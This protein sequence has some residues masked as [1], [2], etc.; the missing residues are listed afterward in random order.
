MTATGRRTRSAVEDQHATAVIRDYEPHPCRR[1][2]GAG[3]VHSRIA[4]C[5]AAAASVR[6]FAESGGGSAADTICRRWGGRRRSPTVILDSMPSRSVN[7]CSSTPLTCAA[8]TA[9]NA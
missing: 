8:I 4:G 7:V 5:M 9:T 3:L 1:V 2:F 6:K